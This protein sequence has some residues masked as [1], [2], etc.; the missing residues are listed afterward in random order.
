MAL[1]STAWA[2]AAAAQTFAPQ[3]PAPI[4]GPAQTVQSG[5]APPNGTSA[6]A[7]QAIIT[8][9]TNANTMYIGAVNG[10]VWATQNGGAIW[11]PLSDT[12]RSLSIAIGVDPANPRVLIAGTGTTSSAG[13]WAA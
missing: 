13:A 5:D 10:G 6:G 8:D 12:Q 9:P 1:I 7:V 2:T 3:G 11:T 4:F